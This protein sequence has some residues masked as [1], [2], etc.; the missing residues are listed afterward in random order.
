MLIGTLRSGAATAPIGS[1]AR[2]PRRDV[3]RGAASPGSSGD[4]SAVA[5]AATMPFEWRSHGFLDT[6]VVRT[7]YYLL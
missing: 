3:P 6:V 5:P 4:R 1:T 2:M 7:H